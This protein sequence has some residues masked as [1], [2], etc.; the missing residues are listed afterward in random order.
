MRRLGGDV[1]ADHSWQAGIAHLSADVLDRAATVE[2][3]DDP[4]DVETFTGDSD[5][6]VADLVWKWAPA[7][8]ATL[9]NWKLQGEYFRRRESGRY[10]GL[11]YDGEQDGWYLQGVWQFIQHWRVGLRH[12]SVFADNGATLDNTMLVS[13]GRHARRNTV[14]VDWSPSEFS[15]LRLQYIDDHVLPEE[16][17]QWY[18]QYIMSLG[19]HGA[20][21]F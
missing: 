3:D 20:H 13:P 9:R 12:D 2:H 17:G 19:A 5:L 21:Q 1:G 7:G 16:D 10:A 8:N 14:M 4:V 6:T 11:P 15:R 18:L